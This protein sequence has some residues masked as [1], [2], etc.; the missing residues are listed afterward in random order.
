MRTGVCVLGFVI[1][2]ACLLVFFVQFYAFAPDGNHLGAVCEGCVFHL[3][4]LLF[5]L[6]LLYSLLCAPLRCV[7]GWDRDL[8]W[9]LMWWARI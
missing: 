2:P 3:V 7:A 8:R 4:L 1:L 5:L 9:L 6:L